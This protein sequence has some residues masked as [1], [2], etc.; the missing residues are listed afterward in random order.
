MSLCVRIFSFY[1]LHISMSTKRI[2]LN[3]LFVCINPITV[4][5]SCEENHSFENSHMLMSVRTVGSDVIDSPT[6]CLPFSE[7][8][9][10]T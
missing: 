5:I 6:V 9:D 7:S 2:D 4:M 8:Q 1:N 3:C 10:E